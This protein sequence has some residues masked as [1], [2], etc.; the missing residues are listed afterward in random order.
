MKLFVY[1]T[2]LNDYQYNYYLKKYVSN[3]R[4][5]FIKGTMYQ[6][7]TFPMIIL[8]KHKK[9][10]MQPQV[11]YGI[12]FDLTFNTQLDRKIFFSEMDAYEGCN[13]NLKN[14]LYFRNPIKVQLLKE[15]VL[16]LENNELAEEV[17][18]FI[19]HGNPKN[20]G[21]RRVIDGNHGRALIAFRTLEPFLNKL[22]PIDYR[23]VWEECPNCGHEVRLISKMIWQ[24][25]P[26]CKVN[27][28]P[29]S[30]CDMDVVNC[31]NCQIY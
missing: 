18:A 28:K 16:D 10:N 8:P 15:N 20:P 1:G 17:E 25:C 3:P 13:N 12:T 21:I 19:Y 11:A 30:L 2:L 27:I 23:Y 5:S 26:I 29:C 9:K 14:S 31:S 6:N 22:N 24:E 7:T 4:L